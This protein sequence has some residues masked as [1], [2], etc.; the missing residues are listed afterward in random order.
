MSAAYTRNIERL[1][2]N[3]AAISQQERNIRTAAAN[4]D[5]NRTISDA[6]RVIS[7]LG[8]LSPK[9]QKRWDERV[10]RMEEQGKKQYE[11]AVIEH[12]EDLSQGAKDLK[13]IKQAQEVG[14]LAF[15]FKTIDEQQ[16]VMEQLKSDMLDSQG[17][18]SNFHARRMSDLSGA[19]LVGF[20]KER[21]RQV[22]L[23]WPDLLQNKLNNS[24]DKIRLPE[25]LEFTAAELRGKP[26]TL[27]MKEAAIYTLS[28]QLYEEMGLGRYSS[29][30][31][32]LQGIT[33]KNG[34]IQKTKDSM[35]ASARKDYNIMAGS[36]DRKR[37]DIAWK[38]GSKDGDALALYHLTVSNTFDHK[39]GRMTRG[40]AWKHVLGTIIGEG[41]V[42]DDKAIEQ[43]R[44][45]MNE[46]IPDWLRTQMGLKIGTTYG[47]QWG[48]QFN[49]AI[50]D[51]KKNVTDARNAENKW[52]KSDGVAIENQFLR[53]GATQPENLTVDRVEEYKDAFTSIGQPVPQSIMKF[54]TA[55]ERDKNK[56][57]IEIKAMIAAQNGY[58]NNNQ[59]NGFNQEAALEFRKEADRIE[60][61]ALTDFQAQ[62]II[63]ANLNTVFTD[64]G[65]TAFHKT[66][67]YLYSLANALED[68]EQQFFSY[69]G[70][71]MYTP[72]EASHVA[73][74]GALGEALGEDGKPIKDRIGVVTEIENKGSKSKYSEPGRLAVADMG[75]AN[76]KAAAVVEAKK[77]IHMNPKIIWDEPLAGQF[78]RDRLTEVM[79][80]IERY[81]VER[82]LGLSTKAVDFYSGV[83]E[84]MHSNT[85]G[86]HGL[87][88]A[89]LR[90]IGHPGLHQEGYHPAIDLASRKRLRELFNFNELSDEDRVDKFGYEEMFD[91]TTRLLNLNN[92]AAF[93][94]GSFML[95]DALDNG[96]GYWSAQDTIMYGGGV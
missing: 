63:K 82:G 54:Q 94:Y 53:E 11:Q 73:L 96:P 91:D 16:R 35:L 31:L 68:Y 44:N 81:G 30:M 12:G 66:P 55:S 19:R 77:Q 74:H 24:T 87:L 88:D 42:D 20:N 2:A 59:L 64:M 13:T 90:A 23:Q 72:K 52:L 43:I 49:Q 75:Y 80:N 47:D 21:L 69:V 29:A 10:A 83:A 89:Q 71:G 1:K 50:S 40:A 15:E 9:L 38:T 18:D 7:Q 34:I 45:L 65:K 25:G 84:G 48:P 5:A 62:E 8:A 61:A 76:V 33:G 46:E 51:I 17:P 36:N 32:E 6:N 92:P 26:L 22:G 37:A 95:Q 78:G 56:D 3:Q 14:E 41:M 57:T 39:G 85:G 67:E 70:S 93:L 60:K 86:Y 4:A 28:D 79:K 58:Y 27:P